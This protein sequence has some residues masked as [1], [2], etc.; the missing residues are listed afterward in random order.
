[1]QCTLASMQQ[2]HARLWE[3]ADLTLAPVLAKDAH[4]QAWPC[5]GR[6]GGWCR[7]NPAAA[8]AA[9]TRCSACVLVRGV[10]N[11]LCLL[12]F[13]LAAENSAQTFHGCCATLLQ[14]ELLETTLVAKPW[15][16]TVSAE[17]VTCISVAVGPKISDQS[18]ARPDCETSYLPSS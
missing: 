9:G 16:M 18:L 15:L 6:R 8:A 1:M 3:G 12:V 5:G 10:A 11:S 17:R 2:R 7:R 13:R 14:Q 4:G